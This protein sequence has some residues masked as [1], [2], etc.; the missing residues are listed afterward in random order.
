MEPDT[1]CIDAENVVTSGEVILPCHTISLSAASLL[2][3]L[4]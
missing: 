3:Q 4:T 1:L 2:H